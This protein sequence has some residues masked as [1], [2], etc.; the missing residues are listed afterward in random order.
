MT[1][2]SFLFVGILQLGIAFRGTIE[3]RKNFSWY[4]LLLLIVVYGLAYENIII[5]IGRFI[6]EGNV[7]LSLN[8]VRFAVHALFT[9]AMMISAFGMLKR[10]QVKFTNN[11]F[12]HSVIC[13]LALALI[14]LGSYESILNIDLVP[15][16]EN[17]VLRYINDFEFMKGPP[18]PAVLTI[19]VVLIFGIILWR[20]INWPYLFIGSAVMFIT[21]ALPSSLLVWQNLGE[22]VF[23][24]GLV[25]TEIHIL[26]RMD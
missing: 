25:F 1:G 7:L 9:P 11:K 16:M 23:A 26:T 8:W 17:G 15:V 14:L 5:S 21:A 12:W 20:K 6:G 19:I 24:G 2:L 13:T 4:S 10:S 22:V 3:T 18:L